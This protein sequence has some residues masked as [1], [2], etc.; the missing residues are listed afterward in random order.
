M[1]V[2]QHNQ[3]I[4]RLRRLSNR[5]YREREKRF[6]VEGVRFVEEALSSTWAV[7]TLVYCPS[8]LSN[9]RGEALPEV[10]KAKGI[11][12]LEV[13]EALFKELAGTQTPQGV[14]AEIRQ[15]P[16]TLEDLVTGELGDLA[17]GKPALLVVVDGVQDPGNLGTIVRSA[18]AA[19]AGGVAILKGAA[20]IYNPKALRATM[21]SIF[22][23]PV[24]QGLS[25]A[26]MIAYLK[27]HK[28]KTVAGDPRAQKVLYE[29]D[30]TIPSAIVAGSE[31]AGVGDDILDLVDE[32]VRIPMPGR[33]ESLNVAISAAII[34]YE[35]LR[36]RGA[37]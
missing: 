30:L 2:G 35:V 31:A 3:R 20:D 26:G 33:A 22:H 27:M 32:R 4:K 7:E 21:G 37:R 29:C 18:D 28:I 17:A 5:H 16:T 13:E 10:A 8:I 14:L 19:G 9:R 15:R 24:T 23:V 6:L 25:A 1:L 36:Q 11:P 12:V 34:L